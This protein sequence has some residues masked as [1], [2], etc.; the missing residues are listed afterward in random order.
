ML[1]IRTAI[2]LLLHELRRD[3]CRILY[4]GVRTLSTWH[5]TNSRV[6]RPMTPGHDS[7]HIYEHAL[8]KRIIDKDPALEAAY[9]W[10]ARRVPFEY[11]GKACETFEMAERSY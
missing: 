9:R 7:A 10:E 2:E 5:G 6:S 11:D 3:E 4:S 1:E 8:A